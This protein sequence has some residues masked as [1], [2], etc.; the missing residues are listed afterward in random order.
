MNIQMR[1]K[2]S[3]KEQRSEWLESH[4]KGFANERRFRKLMN[5]AIKDCKKKFPDLY[6]RAVKKADTIWDHLGIDC[7]LVLKNRYGEICRMPIQI[8]SSQAGKEKFLDESDESSRENIFCVVVNENIPDKKIVR[9][10]IRPIIRSYRKKGGYSE[11][12]KSK[13]YI[14]KRRRYKNP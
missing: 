7:F 13:G 8:K 1:I 5:K 9:Q 6:L 2:V 11:F 3:D 10:V 4:R 12:L 14:E